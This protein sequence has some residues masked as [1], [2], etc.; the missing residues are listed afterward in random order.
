MR[1]SL[2]VM[3][4]EPR[5]AEALSGRGIGLRELLEQLG[6]LLRVMSS[7]EAPHTWRLIEC[8]TQTLVYRHGF[9]GKQQEI[10]YDSYYTC[11]NFAADHD[12][13]TAMLSR[14]D[15]GRHLRHP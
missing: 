4:S 2:R 6:L 14:D 15:S 9:A 1:A 10:G 13:F 3:A 11:H 5:A 12:G 8:A 7:C